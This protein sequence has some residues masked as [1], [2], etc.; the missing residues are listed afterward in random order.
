MSISCGML[1]AIM[2]HRDEPDVTRDPVSE[3]IYYAEVCAA[4]CHPPDLMQG[5]HR[6]WESRYLTA[7]DIDVPLLC[8]TSVM[9]ANGRLTP[10]IR[11]LSLCDPEP[12]VVLRL[13]LSMAKI[14]FRKLR[15]GLSDD[16]FV[17]LTSAMM[18]LRLHGSPF[19]PASPSSFVTAAQSLSQEPD[20]ELVIVEGAEFTRPES[21]QT[22]WNDLDILRQTLADRGCG[23]LLFD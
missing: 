14:S 11:L 9:V 5:L 21:R 22:L 19:L 16:A 13:L 20:C 12:I 3:V 15:D 17:Q 4:A 7:D 1:V 2:P 23:L 8:A 18:R 6:R 10:G